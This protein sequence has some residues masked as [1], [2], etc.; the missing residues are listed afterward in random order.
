MIYPDNFEEKTGFTR[1]RELLADLCLS[2]LGSRKA[3][4]MMFH[5]SFEV[6]DTLTGQTAEMRN[7]CLMEPD[8]PS[9]GYY[10]VTPMFGNIAIQGTF[11]NVE[12]VFALKKSL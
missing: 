12:D 10:D 7:I 11:P 8:F 9:H 6:I 3:D 4:E 5:A 1:I 2:S